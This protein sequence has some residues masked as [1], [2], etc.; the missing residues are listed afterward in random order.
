MQAT[1]YYIHRNRCP[2]SITFLRH[3]NL[4]QVHLIWG[5]NDMC[6]PTVIT[7]NEI[8][9]SYWLKQYYIL[10]LLLT[11]PP[12]VIQNTDK[13]SA[14][15]DND[16]WCISSKRDWKRMHFNCSYDFLFGM[17]HNPM[18]D[19]PFV[20]ANDDELTVFKEA[21]HDFIEQNDYHNPHYFQNMPD[22]LSLLE[23]YWYKQVG[24]ELLD[25]QDEL[26]NIKEDLLL[27]ITRMRKLTLLYNHFRIPLD[28]MSLL[29]EKT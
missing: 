19:L 9:Q 25:I 1:C 28:I 29:L 27:E 10:S 3:N 21:L 26:D 18:E 4:V 12:Y 15:S 14:M 11:R 17:D 6:P 16:T 13:G 2:M 24:A 23:E 20:H 8:L 5:F 22:N 7:Y